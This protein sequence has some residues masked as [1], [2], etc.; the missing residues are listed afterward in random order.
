MGIQ[1]SFFNPEKN[2]L[3]RIRFADNS[4]TI[5]G[6]G[7]SPAET[8]PLTMIVVHRSYEAGISIEP[9]GKTRGGLLLY[10]NEKMFCGIGFS[11]NKMFTFTYG[12]EHSWMQISH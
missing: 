1:W 2:E 9:S 12:Q 7:R 10:Y 3:N 11:R 5:K 4:I 8:S 6:K